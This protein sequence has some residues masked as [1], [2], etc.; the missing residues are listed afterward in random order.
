MSH[1]E[2]ARGPLASLCVFWTRLRV[3]LPYCEPVLST[4]DH[5]L[6]P[7]P[8]SSGS[9][10]GSGR[11][12]L[13]HPCRTRAPAAI[14]NRAITRPRS[15][16]AQGCPPAR[17]AP[18]SRSL[19]AHGESDPLDPVAGSAPEISVHCSFRLPGTSSAGTKR[20]CQSHHH[21]GRSRRGAPPD[22]RVRPSKA[23]QERGLRCSARPMRAEGEQRAAI[24]EGGGVQRGSAD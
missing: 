3:W 22:T 9:D 14:A 6:E 24:V 19:S 1:N 18:T 23:P 17:D 11:S 16:L 2:R 4:R 12:T 20:R 13:T 10:H 8:R 15:S 21:E 7:A 5:D